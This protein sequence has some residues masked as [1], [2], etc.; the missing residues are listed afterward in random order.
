MVMLIN[1]LLI[2][3]LIVMLSSNYEYIDIVD[4]C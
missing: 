2:T 3:L 4:S 1:E